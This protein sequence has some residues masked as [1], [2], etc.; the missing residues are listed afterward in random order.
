MQCTNNNCR[1]EYNEPLSLFN[2]EWAC[3]HCF[4]LIK[5]TTN[6]L[7]ETEENKE[8]FVQGEA[9]LLNALLLANNYSGDVSKKFDEL[10][11]VACYCFQQAA[12]QGNPNAFYRLGYL[13]DKDLIEKNKTEKGRC[14]IALKYYL[15]VC[16]NT[17]D[18]AL[19]QKAAIALVK[20]LHASKDFPNEA[21][22]YYIEYE[23]YL[24]GIDLTK[25]KVRANYIEFVLDTLKATN[26]AGNSPAFGILTVAANDIELLLQ[27][28]K[29]FSPK[30]VTIQIYI[31]GQDMFSN[32][33]K[34][35]F[36][37]LG[38]WKYIDKR[39]LDLSKKITILFCKKKFNAKSIKN[40][41]KAEKIYNR[42]SGRQWQ[43][44]LNLMTQ[45]ND[46]VFYEDDLVYFLNKETVDSGLN[47]LSRKACN[48]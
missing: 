44:M 40:K 15:T 29:S 26:N 4:K 8:L 22:Q 12:E 35:K 9:S 10:I 30:T 47:N 33:A 16:K 25:V 13:Y 45:N 37:N 46:F 31:D 18:E 42:I 19:K 41:H 3:P 27:H 43:F 38:E 21:N 11:D 5:L 24:K 6:K 20:M 2:G 36:K 7:I 48:K 28:A 23:K 1:K 34:H 17:T 32:G 14:Q 39:E